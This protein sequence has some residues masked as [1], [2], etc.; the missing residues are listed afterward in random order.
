[1]AS[2]A[3]SAASTRAVSATAFATVPAPHSIRFVLTGAPQNASTVVV[4]TTEEEAD[5]RFAKSP[6]ALNVAADSPAAQDFK[7]KKSALQLLYG[8]DG[9]RVLFVGLGKQENVTVDVVRSATHAAVARLRQLK[10]ANASVVVPASIAS[11]PLPAALDA[12]TRTAVLSNWVF[13]AHLTKNKPDYVQE[14][15]LMVPEKEIA[16]LQKVVDTAQTITECTLFARELG[17]TRADIM[18]PAHLAALAQDLAKTHGL[19]STVLDEKQLR[20]QGYHLLTAVGQAAQHTARLV[21]I[22]YKGNAESKENIAIVGKGIT[23]DSGGLNLKPTGGI[24]TMYLDMSGAAV[25]LATIKALALLKPKVNVIGVA[26]LAENAID[27]LA[28][29]PHQIIPSAKGTV[30]IGNTDAEGRLALADALTYVQKHYEPKQIIDLATL[31]GACVV[32]LGEY[33]AGVFSN[34]DDLAHNLVQS[35]K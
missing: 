5:G 32:A 1:M 3:S 28:Y 7:G 24:E 16:S 26:A 14:L 12:V 33:M 10:L 18:N 35:G 34:D 27:S 20:D 2:A 31:T 8:T 23:F 29:K 13:D 21:V 4:F 15:Q 6:V 22:E 25:V 19:K 17:N 11:V 30:E 9:R